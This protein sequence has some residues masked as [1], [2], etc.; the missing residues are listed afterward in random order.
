VDLCQVYGLGAPDT[1][2]LRR[3]DG[4]GKLKSQ[5]REDGEYPCWLFE[6]DGMRVRAEFRDLSYINEEGTGYRAPNVLPREFDTPER[7]RSLFVSGLER[8]NSSIFY[9]AINTVFLREHN[10]L[11]DELARENP[12]WDEDRLFETARNANIAQLLKLI[13]EDYIN[14]ISPAHFRI[15]HEP[16]FA[17]GCRWYR[18]NRIAAE[19]NLLYRWHSLVPETIRLGG[20]VLADSEFRFNDRG[21]MENMGLASVIDAAS[22]QSA[23]RITLEN[24]ARFLLDAELAAI[25]KGRAWRLQPY[26]DYRA[27]FKLPRLASF[28]ELTR[29]EV[30]A[31]RLHRLYG[32]VDKVD[33]VVGLLAE[34][35]HSEDAVLGNLMAYMV[36]V[37]AFS[38]ALTNPLLAKR[39][40]GEGAFGRAGLRSVLATASFAD[41]VARNVRLPATAAFAV[42][43]RR[44]PRDA[45]Y[46][47]L[48]KLQDI[49][50]LVRM[51]TR[52]EGYFTER[53]A[54]YDSTVFGANLYQPTLVVLDHRA[55]EPLF[56]SR[57]FAQD[58]G[59]SWAVP[60]KALTGSLP[61]IFAEG[62][63]HD[64]PKALYLKL[65]AAR[66]P[67]LG[68]ILGEVLQ[69]FVSRWER[70]GPGFSFR[71]ELE[72]FAATF[73]C[74]W[75]LGESYD[76]DRLRRLY[77]NIFSH[78]FPAV[79]DIFRGGI[80]RESRRIHAEWV[81]FVRNA[82]E[83][84]RTIMPLARAEGL[85]DPGYISEQIAFLIGMNGFLGT[86]NLLKSLIGELSLH[87]E[88]QER[89]RGSHAV[90]SAPPIDYFILETLRLHPPVTFV[91]GRA[92]RSRPLASS[93]G[94]FQVREGE[95]VMG[96]LP[97]AMRDPA[98]FSR[99]DDFDPERYARNPAIAAQVIWAR[100][101]NDRAPEERD[102]VCAGKPEALMI[103]R[104]F[105]LGLVAS[106]EWR[107]QDTPRWE[108]N[109]FTLDVAAPAGD[110]PVAHFRR[111]SEP[112]PLH[113]LRKDGAAVPLP[114]P[115][116]RRP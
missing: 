17:E 28:M 94:T 87:P 44:P 72:R 42:A 3:L 11:C 49:A 69:Q 56:E 62:V 93:S 47:P 79:T 13:V 98:V 38:Q 36:G 95:L 91:F 114:Q 105:L 30:L 74:R 26:N 20:R 60:P 15:F 99:P 29:D 52:W 108:R 64:W 33:L 55:I 78:V 34:R 73:L 102:R 111:R 110:M 54:R 31:E 89:V 80:Y 8:G 84:D 109:R 4:S 96:V 76:A 51:F 59:F 100:G 23:G 66:R 41:I 103:A 77:G 1:R 5:S 86:Q 57:D 16:G 53:R 2:L 58:H 6:D 48:G 104:S 63:D 25:A 115:P 83:F 82:P 113:A 21:L 37:D 65:L 24:T 10:R 19:F 12:D 101:H 71:E 61:S 32:S 81:A 70:L 27:F 50:N 35:R 18:T 7:R 39:V 45:R 68:T 22:G 106:A 75:L 14:H 88:W 90:G 97:I 92:R 9:S 40:F 116:Q 107:L 43:L 85:P 67:V 112:A 46:F